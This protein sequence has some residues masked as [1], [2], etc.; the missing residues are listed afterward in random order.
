MN[1]LAS[2]SC[3]QVFGGSPLRIH[4][5]TI[6]S[7]FNL[8]ASLN[9]VT[10]EKKDEESGSTSPSLSPSSSSSSSSLSSIPSPNLPPRDAIKEVVRLFVSSYLPP[11][12]NWKETRNGTLCKTNYD[13][14]DAFLV[15]ATALK[16]KSDEKILECEKEFSHFTKKFLESRKNDSMRKK[17]LEREDADEAL[18]VL[19]EKAVAKRTMTLP[20]TESLKAET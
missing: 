2:F 11:D 6:R 15:S 19:F 5:N 14:C 20:R 12:Y 4:P 10:K 8:K 1:A 9:S 3:A 16:L 13:R 18:R 7:V 17:F